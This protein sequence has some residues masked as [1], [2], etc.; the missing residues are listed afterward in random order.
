MIRVCQGKESGLDKCRAAHIGFIEYR[1]VLI[2]I[3]LFLTCTI[4]GGSHD[5]Y[6]K[7]RFGAKIHH[8]A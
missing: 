5:V 6:V 7:L 4:S 2:Y 1:A 8:V 3:F